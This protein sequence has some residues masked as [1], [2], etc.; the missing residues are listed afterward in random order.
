[1]S[2]PRPVDPALAARCGFCHLDP[3]Q[4]VISYHIYSGAPLA[5]RIACPE[6]GYADILP[7]V[8]EPKQLVEL[9]GRELV[10]VSPGW[11][12]SWASCRRWVQVAGGEF[13][14]GPAPAPGG[15]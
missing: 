8:F 2:R 11:R 12:C 4:F 13:R 6:C 1:V 9:A 3:G 5:L 7:V 14:V 10:T 15:A